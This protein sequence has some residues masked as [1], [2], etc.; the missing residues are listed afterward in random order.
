[1]WRPFAQCGGRPG[2]RAPMSVAASRQLNVLHLDHSTEPGGAE[3]ALLRVVTHADTWSPS[4]RIPE[5]NADGNGV[6]SS[7]ASSPSVTLVAAGKKQK[8]GASQSGGLVRM[9]KFAVD[10]LAESARLKFSKSFAKADVVHANTSRSAVYGAV[11]CFLTNKTFVVHLRDMTTSESL[12]SVGY[13]LFTKLALRRADGVIANSRSTL[14]SAVPHLRAKTTRVVI[15]SPIGFDDR[16][17][18]VFSENVGAVGMVARIDSWKGHALL[19][20]AFAAVLKGSETR[21]VFAGGAAFGKEA[22]LTE[23]TDRAQ[24]LGIADQVDFLGHVTDVRPVID[25]LD[26]CVQASTRPEPLGQNVLQYLAAGKTVIAVDAGGPAEWVTSGTNG[27]LVEIESV[28]ALE[29]ALKA[30]VGDSA[31][32]HKLALGASETSGIGT[33]GEI[34]RAH[35]DFFSRTRTQR[36]GGNRR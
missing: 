36:R 12:G 20:E 24:Q 3:L 23:F 32:R 19:M 26:I 4:I 21:L 33:D 1:M 22:I 25:R 11:A 15:A 8:P 30:L 9:V 14:A 6:F 31:L 18:P 28:S 34:A 29:A 7:L 2:V 13:A 16:T 10:A 17:V 35:G 27:L 5:G